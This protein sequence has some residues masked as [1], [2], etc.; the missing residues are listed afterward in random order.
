MRLKGRPHRFALPMVAASRLFTQRQLH[1]RLI[2]D[3]I[4]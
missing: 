4:P 3:R 2:Q 1:R